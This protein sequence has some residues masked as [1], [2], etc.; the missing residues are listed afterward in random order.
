MNGCIWAGA[1]GLG[2][3]VD[4]ILTMATV[5]QS[6]DYLEWDN[7]AHPGGLDGNCMASTP[8]SGHKLMCLS[9]GQEEIEH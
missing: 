8:W 5:L 4:Q 1:S 6:C 7:L 9:Y 3:F 2:S